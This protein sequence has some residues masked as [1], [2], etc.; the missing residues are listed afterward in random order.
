[1]APTEAAAQMSAAAE[2]TTH[3]SATTETATVSTPTAASPAARKCV[4]GQSPGKSGGRS[5]KD[6]G[7]A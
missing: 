4:S 1:M 3:M 7:L 2:P 6:H 5:Q